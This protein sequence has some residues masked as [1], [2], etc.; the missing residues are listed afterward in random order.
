MDE[1][2]PATVRPLVIPEI[3]SLPAE[4]DV[5]NAERVDAELRAAVRPGVTVVIADMTHTTYC[6]S[7]GI[8]HLV[9][10]NDHAAACAAELRLAVQ[11]DAVLR[12][13]ELLGVDRMLRIYPS[14]GDALTNTPPRP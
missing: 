6:A 12:V 11:S 3:V 10:A 14:L 2:R 7:S 1:T 4:I 8:R 9:L 5:T 13:L